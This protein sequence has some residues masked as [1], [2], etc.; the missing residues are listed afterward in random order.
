LLGLITAWHC[1]ELIA[2]PC[3]SDQQQDQMAAS[4]PAWEHRPQSVVVHRRWLRGT[5]RVPR[6]N[7]SA[8]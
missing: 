6:R 8:R 5:G 3:G 7:G 2:G 1:V 4:T